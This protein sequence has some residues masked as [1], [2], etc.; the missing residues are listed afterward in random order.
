MRDEIK[1]W[2]KLTGHSRQWLADKCAVKKAT[3][4]GWLGKSSKKAIP[5]PACLIIRG[6]IDNPKASPDFDLD[7]YEKIERLAK[8]EGKTVKQ[9]MHDLAMKELA[10]KG[11]LLLIFAAIIGGVFLTSA[12]VGKWTQVVELDSVLMDAP[13]DIF[14]GE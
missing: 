9:W 13:H 7:Q 8:A 2:L 1:Q 6:L 5:G 4:D 12:D 11:L 10:A 14:W 3:V